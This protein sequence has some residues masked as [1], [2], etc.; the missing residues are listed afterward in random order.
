MIRIDVFMCAQS[1][2]ELFFAEFGGFM[3]CTQ[4]DETARVAEADAMH[5]RVCNSPSEAMMR[6]AVAWLVDD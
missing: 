3:S 2:R 5:R 1:F 4:G 6:K